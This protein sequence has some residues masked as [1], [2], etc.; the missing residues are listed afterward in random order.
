MDLYRLATKLGWDFKQAILK[1]DGG[2]L[3]DTS[4]FSMQ[5]LLVDPFRGSV[6]NQVELGMVAF[7]GALSVQCTVRRPLI[8]LGQVLVKVSLHRW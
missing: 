7:Q 8:T 3:T 4:L 2:V 5:K 1:L 6:S